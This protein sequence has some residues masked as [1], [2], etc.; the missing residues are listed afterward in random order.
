MNKTTATP[1]IEKI[2][3]FFLPRKVE[4]QINQ[5]S[6][7]KKMLLDTMENNSNNKLDTIQS[8]LQEFEKE[9]KEAQEILQPKIHWHS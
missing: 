6:E 9:L 1:W 5:F 3:Y 7:K 8:S 2:F 4:E